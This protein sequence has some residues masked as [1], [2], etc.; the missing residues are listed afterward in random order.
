MLGAME[1]G[2]VWSG[3]DQIEQLL[4]KTSMTPA[5]QVTIRTLS[6]ADDAAILDIWTSG[7]QADLIGID[8]RGF[9]WQLA[10]FRKDGAALRGAIAG[11]KLVGF[12][13]V[14]PGRVEWLAVRPEIWRLGVARAL[15]NEAH[16]ISP[17]GLHLA[18]H[19]NN[20]R[21]IAFYE[22]LGFRRH[23]ATE[24][25]WLYTSADYKPAKN[26]AAQELGR[27]GGAARAKSMSAERRA[28]IAQK[29]Q[30]KAGGKK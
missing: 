19:Q 23:H 25:G 14:S 12:I 28:E 4:E 11:G 21:A 24:D 8:K 3:S 18:V 26:Q 13:V 17:G 22:A 29:R 5:R 2:A 16:R 30:P 10:H 9:S 27:E 1:L 7:P 20:K 6:P 15:M